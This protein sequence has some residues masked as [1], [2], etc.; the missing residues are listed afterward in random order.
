MSERR[1]ASQITAF[2]TQPPSQEEMDA[3]VKRK[4]NRSSPGLNGI[5]YL[6][7][8]KCPDIRR[9][10]YWI[11][12]RVWKEHTV[13][14]S[15][16]VGRQVLIPK[17][18]DTS[19]PGLMRPI[20]VLNVEGRLFFTLYQQRLCSFMIA[21]HYMKAQVQKAFLPGVAGCVEHATI[22]SEMFKDAKQSQR[23][24]CTSW[25]DLANAYGSIRHSMVMFVL[26]WFHVPPSFSRILGTYYNSIFIQVQTKH[27]S[28]IWF[29]LEI[30]VPQ[31]CTAS[32]IIFNVSFQMVLDIHAE[33]TRHIPRIGYNFRDSDIT[34]VKPTYADDVALVTNSPAD[35]QESIDAFAKGL[36]WSKTLHFKPAKC[37]SLALRK[38]VNGQKTRFQAHQKHRYSCFDPLLHVGG[39]AVKFIGNDDPPMFKYLGA[40]FQFDLGDHFVRN[41]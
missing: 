5:P 27:W 15:W 31:G 20:T 26:W 21:N 33:H 8:K 12:R 36:K 3:V 7:Y 14:Q 41:M 10:L 28:S 2:D 32:T 25:L 24:I 17:S 29:P 30:G 11:F 39:V 38:F 16:K 22:H 35:N 19:K 37:R 40:F 6:V 23:A 13:P 18:N 1:A 9:F 34:I 4:S